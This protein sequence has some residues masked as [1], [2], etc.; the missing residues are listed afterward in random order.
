M[1]IDPPNEVRIISICSASPLRFLTYP[2]QYRS[3]TIPA[4]TYPS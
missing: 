1:T 4:V 2:T 3:S